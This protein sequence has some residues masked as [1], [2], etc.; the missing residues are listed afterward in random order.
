MKLL[1]KIMTLAFFS[2]AAHADVC[3]SGDSDYFCI[4][5][6]MAPDSKIQI[7]EFYD[8]PLKI[9]SL[10]TAELNAKKIPLQ[11]EAKWESPYFG[12]G[13]ALYENRFRLMILGGTVRL[14]EMTVD[15]YA[16]VICHELG[17]ILGGAPYQT[18]PLSDW[19]SS[20]GQ[21]D[22]F[23][24]TVCLPRYYAAQKLAAQQILE[25]IEIAGFEMMN[26]FNKVEGGDLE[27][28]KIDTSVVKET[29]NNNYPSLQ[30][31]YE[32]FR[33]STANR[34]TCWFKK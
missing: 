27:R 31:R 16:A 29:L 19:A 17:H 34:P 25:K 15:A 10:F 4:T 12:A 32:N 5:P 21:S 23:A 8:I 1:I 30:C 24:S 33:N 14:K 18:I 11:L 9:M 28:F 20:E 3:P 13:V 7:F 2:L 6:E 26:V 22:Y